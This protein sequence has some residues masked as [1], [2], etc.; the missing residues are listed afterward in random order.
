M[1]VG[2]LTGLS[3]VILAWG[4]TRGRTSG[5][6]RGAL[7]QERT[8]R[9]RLEKQVD[10]LRRWG[11][12]LEVRLVEKRLPTPPRPPEFEPD[13]GLEEEEPAEGSSKRLKAVRSG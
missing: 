11:V 6:S 12:R 8:E 9:R 1:I 13:W 2:I 3:G 7:K 10:A 4:Q 5:A